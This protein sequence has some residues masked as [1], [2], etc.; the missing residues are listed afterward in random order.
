M[1]PLDCTLKKVEIDGQKGPLER[2]HRRNEQLVPRGTASSEEVARAVP[3][4]PQCHQEIKS[5]AQHSSYAFLGRATSQ[6]GT[7]AAVLTA[8]ITVADRKEAE[9]LH[10]GLLGYVTPM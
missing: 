2:R 3:A 7:G 9:S 10:Q 4:R 8:V 5:G 6:L 1:C